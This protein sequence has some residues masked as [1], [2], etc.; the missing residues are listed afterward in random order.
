MTTFDENLDPSFPATS[1]RYSA[2]D[3]GLIPG[4]GSICSYDTKCFRNAGLCLAFLGVAGALCWDLD[5]W[6]SA[7]P[8]VQKETVKTPQARFLI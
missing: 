5:T 8:T 7:V 3:R 4:R 6:Y 2:A 1:P